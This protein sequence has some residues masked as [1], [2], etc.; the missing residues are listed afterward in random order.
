[1]AFCPFF[2]ILE[3]HGPVTHLS[4][5]D[6][7]VLKCALI[8]LYELEKSRD[9]AILVVAFKLTVGRGFSPECSLSINEPLGRPSPPQEALP[10]PPFW[11]LF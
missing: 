2:Q 7:L 3:F 9:F 8:F 10:S 1:M 5:Q 11:S 4:L 6:V